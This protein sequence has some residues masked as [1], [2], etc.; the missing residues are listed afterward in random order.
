[1]IISG[2]ENVYPTE[3]ENVLYQH[4]GV[5]E[6]AVIGEEDEE[7]G[8]R[9]IAHVVPDGDLTADELDDFCRERRSR[10]VQATATVRVPRRPPQESQRQDPEIQA[11]RR[12][13]SA[14]GGAIGMWPVV[15]SISFL[16]SGY[17]GGLVPLFRSFMYS[18]AASNPSVAA[19]R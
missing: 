12:G 13:L 5:A 9:I 1:M 18:S 2:G 6:V 14:I 3:V 7:W 17:S 15:R 19:M 11:P 10:R 16:R 8:E 4:D